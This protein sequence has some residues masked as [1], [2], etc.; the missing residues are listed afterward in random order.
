MENLFNEMLIG[1]P[2]LEQ[3]LKQLCQTCKLRSEKFFTIR[4]KWLTVV[5]DINIVQKALTLGVCTRRT[6]LSTV[7]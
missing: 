5:N 3:K 1:R 2:K 4:Q 6:F 7:M